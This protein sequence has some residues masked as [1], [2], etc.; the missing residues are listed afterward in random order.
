MAYQCETPSA[1]VW[2]QLFS[3]GRTNDEQSTFWRVPKAPEE[4]YD[5]EVFGTWDIEVAEAVRGAGQ[6]A[7]M[8]KRMGK[9]GEKRPYS[10]RAAV[11]GRESRERIRA[12]LVL[13]RG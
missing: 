11:K 3:E 2:H 4:L 9:D 1:R 5:L 6:L 8:T 10:G 13:V 7:G 12:G